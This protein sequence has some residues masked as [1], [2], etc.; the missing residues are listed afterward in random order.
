[1]DYPV[2]SLP[3]LVSFLDEQVEPRIVMD[4][5]YRIVAANRAY[6]EAFA[7]GGSV[8]GRHCYEVSHHFSAPCDQA[9]EP[10][11]LR[12]S[13]ESGEVQR[14][15]HL[16]HTAHG[17]EHV[18]VETTP[19]RDEAGKIIYFVETMRV[20]KQAS[21]SPAAEG[22]VGRSASFKKMLS[23]AMRVAP[24]NATVLLLGETGTGKELV[25]RMLHETGRNA[26]GPFVAVDCSGLTESLFESELFGYEKGAFTGAQ[27]RKTGLVESARGGTLFLDEVGDIPLPQ[28]VKLL[29]LLESGTYRRVGSV[30][31]LRADFRLICATHRNIDRLVEE[32]AFRRDLFHR[33]S[34]FPIH[35]PSLA[36]RVEDIPLLADSFLKRVAVGQNLRLSESA[37]EALKHRRYLGNIR[38]LR[39]L[40]ERAT[41]LADGEAINEKHFEMDTLPNKMLTECSPPTSDR[42]VIDT[43]LPL[44]EVERR[45]IDWAAHRL[46]GDRTLLARQLAVSLRTLYRKLSKTR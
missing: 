41:I 33:I 29:R 21:G 44:E 15:L 11:P 14:V 10:C 1:M 23:L 40:I 13:Q 25:A 35:V 6:A 8:A 19:I 12:M 30:E 18:D 7:P 34:T 26:G 36:E 20:L 42:F 3:E 4:A 27:H 43:L 38:E 17:E 2:K 16:H 37:I 31:T 22:L 46:P 45:Y 32:E 9:G 5:E 28:Q 24:T 39:N